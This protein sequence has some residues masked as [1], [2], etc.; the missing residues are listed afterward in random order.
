MGERE[1]DGQME[2]S[3]ELWEPV[4]VPRWAETIELEIEGSQ[5]SGYWDA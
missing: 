1:H 2:L 4:P 3:L 5:D